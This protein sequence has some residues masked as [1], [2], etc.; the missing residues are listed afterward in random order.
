MND[1]MTR[2]FER[3]KDVGFDV[4][5]Q[6]QRRVSACNLCGKGVFTVVSHQDRY[7][8]D[9]GACACRKCGLVFLNPVMTV[10]GYR[11]F[12]S[13]VYR[14]LV[15]AYHGRLIDANSIQNEQRAYAT[16]R[17]K[18]LEPFVAA[19]KPSNLLDVGGSTGVVAHYFSTCFNL[20]ATVVDPAPLEIQK[21]KSLGLNTVTGVAEEF[22]P[23]DRKFDVVVMCQTVDHLLDINRTLKAIRRL[24]NT[25]GG[26]FFVDIVDFR[27]AYLRESSVNKAIKVDH[28]YYLTEGTIEAF[29]ALAG[30]EILLV[31]YA[32]DCLH[33]GY[34]CRPGRPHS[35]DDALPE[36][37]TRTE[38]WREIRAVQIASHCAS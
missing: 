35:L 30:F 25:D 28:P 24:I 11:E 32:E 5:M 38:L 27:A 13:T 19:V 29:L 26:L 7:G 34:V 10:E 16:E 14:P 37:S 1:P 21:A 9:V 22:D 20:E 2:R 18:L 17:A 33:V 8:Y 4:S 36:P 31:D 12:Y 15:S 6:P 23:G 3:I